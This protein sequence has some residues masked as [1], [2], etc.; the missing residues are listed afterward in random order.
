MNKSRYIDLILPPFLTLVVLLILVL[1]LTRMRKM[2]SAGADDSTRVT[3]ESL[4]LLSAEQPLEESIE[5]SP[6]DLDRSLCL[7]TQ[8]VGSRIDGSH[9]AE[10]SLSQSEIEIQVPQTNT[11]KLENILNSFPIVVEQLDPPGL[12]T[13]LDDKKAGFYKA[14]VYISN[15]DGGFSILQGPVYTKDGYGGLAHYLQA[16][17]DHQFI[18]RLSFLHGDAS[19]AE[20]VGSYGVA[21]SGRLGTSSVKLKSLGG[22][23]TSPDILEQLL[24]AVRLFS[25]FE[26]EQVH[27]EAKDE[28]EASELELLASRSTALEIERVGKQVHVEN[29]GYDLGIFLAYLRFGEAVLGRP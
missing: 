22:R 24:T 25:S 10:A 6:A 14:G 26:Q 27:F 28:N 7:Y 17:Q 2:D 29:Y 12:L 5:I 15:E 19:R 21:L 11:R 8:L 9:L 4:H 23:L 18:L 3:T 13:L 16:T 20:A 1:L